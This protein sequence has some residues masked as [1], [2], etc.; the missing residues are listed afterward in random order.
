M[1][2]IAPDNT[3]LVGLRS[4]VYSW[5]SVKVT[6]FALYVEIM[7]DGKIENRLVR[8]GKSAIES[9]RRLLTDA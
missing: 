4:A 8:F 6:L 5:A 3:G 1:N 7:P 9:F 2:V